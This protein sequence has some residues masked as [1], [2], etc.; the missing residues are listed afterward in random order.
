M[1][2]LLRRYFG[3]PRLESLYDQLDSHVV[4][5]EVALMG[6][7]RVD[8]KRT[9]GDGDDLLLEFGEAVPE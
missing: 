4:R 9:L 5:A 1:Q 6:I 7:Y 2:N 8:L 3:H